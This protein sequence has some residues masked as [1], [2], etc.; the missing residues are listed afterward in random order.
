MGLR[1]LVTFCAPFRYSEVPGSQ[2]S[3]LFVIPPAC[4]VTRVHLP[5]LLARAVKGL[6]SPGIS[7]SEACVDALLGYL[8][9]KAQTALGR[10]L[11]RWMAAGRKGSR[12]ESGK[13]W[14]GRHHLS[15]QQ[16]C[17]RLNI[18]VAAVKRNMVF[19]ESA[20]LYIRM[21][22]SRPRGCV[23]TGRGPQGLRY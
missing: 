7:A 2:I 4:L 8:L 16:L 21:F 22:P 6:W 1:L 17:G 10:T 9:R 13:G 11:W 18:G 14:R 15:S 3:L 23:L 20:H 12:R 19:V 5:P